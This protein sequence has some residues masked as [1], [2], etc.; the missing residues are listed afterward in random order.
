MLGVGMPERQRSNR[1]VVRRQRKKQM[2]EIYQQ[3]PPSPLKGSGEK[4]EDGVSL[5]LAGTR[6]ETYASHSKLCL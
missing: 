6:Q 2:K 1:E 4:G 3:G 5:S